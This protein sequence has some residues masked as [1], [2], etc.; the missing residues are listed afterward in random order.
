V[1]A[2]SGLLADFPFR[3]KASEASLKP[4]FE[5]N[6]SAPTDDRIFALDRRGLRIGVRAHRRGKWEG[7]FAV[8]RRSYPTT[9]TFHAH[10]YPSP[11]SIWPKDQSGEAVFAVQTG[12]TGQSGRIDYVFV[13]SSTT[14]GVTHWEVGHAVGRVANA[15]TTI[16]WQ[17]PLVPGGATAQDI[18]LR[19]DG[20]SLLAVYFGRRRVYFSH[21]LKLGIT[22]PLQPYLEVQSLGTGYDARFRDFW[23]AGESSLTLAGL[24]AGDRVTFAPDGSRTLVGVASRAGSVHLALDPTHVR[25]TARVTIVGA[26]HMRRIG[27][28]SYTGGDV[29]RLEVPGLAPLRSAPGPGPWLALG[30]G[31]GALALLVLVLVSVRRRRPLRIEVTQG[32]DGLGH[33]L[34]LSISNRQRRSVHVEQV[35][36]RVLGRVALEPGN[37]APSVV[38][39]HVARTLGRGDG[40]SE[41][42]LL[43]EEWVA[44]GKRFRVLLLLKS[45]ERPYR[46]A[47]HRARPSPGGAG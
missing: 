42:F 45:H 14:A 9:S 47:R 6:G 28:V 5:L 33:E 26:G 38:P 37:Y 19:T 15:T 34:A 13:A 1:P 40:L 12:S 35:S 31:A 4:S 11:R 10:V 22:S 21:R 46:S 25:G 23:V 2:R 18:T 29:L 20:R 16:V 36:L 27:L 7:F 39:H 41:R 17:S 44:Q 32:A 30:I 8:T 24:R 43:P 3:A